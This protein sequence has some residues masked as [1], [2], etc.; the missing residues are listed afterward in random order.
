VSREH[1]RDPPSRFEQLFR[2][3]RHDLLAYAVR[4]SQSADDAADVVA[5]TFLI[6]W[7]KLDSIPH[8]EAAPGSGCSASLG[9]SFGEA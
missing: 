7:R 4:R 5:E 3:T 6:A 9:T 8:G 1:N 2:N